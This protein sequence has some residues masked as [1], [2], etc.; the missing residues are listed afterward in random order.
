M[1]GGGEGGSEAQGRGRGS[2][3][4]IENTRRGAGLPGGGG[5]GLEDV[6]HKICKSKKRNSPRGSAGVATL[7]NGDARF[8]A[9]SEKNKGG[10]KTQG[11]E[12][13][14]KTPSQKRFWTPPQHD[15]FPPP[16]WFRPVVFL[17]GNRHRP[18]KSHFLGP[19]K[20]VL[21]AALYGTFPPP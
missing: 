12:T 3:L 2:V 19:P 4:F 10:W 5:R 14:H 21:E 15:T 9:L 18:V 20:L 1:L 17:R 6:P 11:R 16:A 13:Y 8:G 7:T